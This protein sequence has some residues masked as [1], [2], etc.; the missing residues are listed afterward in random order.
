MDAQPYRLL[1]LSLD[2]VVGG[3]MLCNVG[4]ATRLSMIPSDD[5][6][7]GAA[8][9]APVSSMI[10]MPASTARSFLLWTTDLTHTLACGT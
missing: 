3:W 8:T 1:A 7:V 10:S 2:H 9:Q 5:L 6:V 4:N